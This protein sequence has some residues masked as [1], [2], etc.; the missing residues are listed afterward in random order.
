MRLAGVTAHLLA[1]S[2]QPLG[3]GSMS[4]P[5]VMLPPL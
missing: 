3:D 1:S 4:L 2:G 5:A